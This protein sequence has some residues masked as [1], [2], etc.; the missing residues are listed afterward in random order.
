MAAAPATTPTMIV[1]GPS[2]AAV[3]TFQKH[4]EGAQR[5]LDELLARSGKAF[6]T[7]EELKR[8]PWIRRRTERE[9]TLHLAPSDDERERLLVLV[10]PKLDFLDQFAE[11]LPTKPLTPA[12]GSTGKPVLRY[13]RRQAHSSSAPSASPLQRRIFDLRFRLYRAPTWEHMWATVEDVCFVW[14][15]AKEAD[16]QRTRQR[17]AMRTVGLDYSPKLEAAAHLILGALLRAPRRWAEVESAGRAA[18]HSQ[19]TLRNAR[20]RL[21][22]DGKIERC[23]VG[24]ALKASDA[25]AS[26]DA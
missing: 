18:G 12:L 21:R 3:R 20:D 25:S 10:K 23:R 19:K 15:R 17:E 1:S 11:S 26:P 16:E 22:G 6:P 2:A 8:D 4:Q 13:A 5:V 7:I 14:S 9:R 24:W